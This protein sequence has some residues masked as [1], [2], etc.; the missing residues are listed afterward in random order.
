MDNAKAKIRARDRRNGFKV[1]TGPQFRQ[2][3]AQNGANL[4]TL[5]K[6]R[7]EI[8]RLQGAEMG[9]E[10]AAHIL[11]A[12]RGKLE[13]ELCNLADKLGFAPDLF[14]FPKSANGR[15]K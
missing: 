8:I 5:D 12:A 14:E 1:L 4:K 11:K 13:R 7:S 9:L 15:G 6:I 10:T 2:F 3:E